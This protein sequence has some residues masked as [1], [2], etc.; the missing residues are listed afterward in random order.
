[1]TAVLGKLRH[2]RRR[3]ADRMEQPLAR[4]LE[5]V[6]GRAPVIVPEYSFDPR[7]RWG[8]NEPPLSAIGERLAAGR[9]RYEA[10]VAG[11]GE[12]V[13]WAGT[14][15]REMW[16]ND[17]WGGLDAMLQVAQLKA[18]NPALYLEVGSGWSTSFAR[19]AIEDFGLRTTIVSIDPVPR[20]DIDSMCDEVVR[21]PAESVPFEVFDRLEPGDVFLIDGSHLAVMNADATYLLL[22]VLPR[23]K[24]GVLVGVH[25]IF[26]PWDY[27]PTWEGR[28]YGEQYVLGGFVLGGHDG[29]QVTLPTWWVCHDAGFDAALAPVWAAVESHFGRV[30]S[31]FW[32]ERV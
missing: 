7:P 24:P 3:A 27:P 16:D 14:V 9:S 8:W 1:M 13:E 19:R 31:S 20:A 23:L 28:F 12:L 6:S 15:P 30:A 11:L 32:M 2:V 18:R 17:F 25:D 5:R 10:T 4:A 26:L 21:A 29:W 22:D